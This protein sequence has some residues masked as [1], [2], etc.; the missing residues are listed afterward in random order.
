MLLV[1]LVA[2]SMLDRAIAGED[3][4]SSPP[5]E[6]NSQAVGGEDN[7]SVAMQIGYCYR[8]LGDLRLA[9]TGT[10]A[11]RRPIR[12]TA[13]LGSITAYGRSSRPTA[14]RPNII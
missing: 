10:S 5:P 4:P 13:R 12:T 2:G 7:A 14:T 3:P 1:A 9:Q 8:K 6:T 11:R